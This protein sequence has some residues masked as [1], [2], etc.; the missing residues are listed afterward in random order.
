MLLS[1]IDA[2]ENRDV[3]TM[4]IPNAFIQTRVEDEKDQCV[5]RLCGVLMDILKD[6][7][8]GVYSP[9]VTKNRNGVKSLL[10]QCLNAIYSAMITSL[11]VYKKFTKSLIL[12]R[13]KVNPYDPCIAN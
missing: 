3:T 9:F 1:I 2:E 4:D 7:V 12:I 5:I 11:L 10:V 13:F 8:P 6:I